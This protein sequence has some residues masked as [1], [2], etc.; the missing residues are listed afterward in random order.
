MYAV[1]VTLIVLVI[2]L[3]LF[4]LHSFFPDIRYYLKKL[5]RWD[6]GKKVKDKP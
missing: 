1:K 2:C 6:W 5:W 3:V 4:L